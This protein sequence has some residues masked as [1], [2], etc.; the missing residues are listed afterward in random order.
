MTLI[1]EADLCCGSR[2]A[3]PVHQQRA[4]R[5]QPELA[6]VVAGRKTV[7]VTKR[8]VKSKPASTNNGREIGGMDI[9]RVGGM[10]DLANPP[11]DLNGIPAAGARRCCRRTRGAAIAA[12]TS[13]ITNLTHEC[14][15]CPVVGQEVT[16][17]SKTRT[18]VRLRI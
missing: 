9:L 4:R 10:E 17:E 13:K 2:D 1:G 12:T 14:A 6:L 15:P 18:F 16:R 11:G 7:G 8:A 5:A 3:P